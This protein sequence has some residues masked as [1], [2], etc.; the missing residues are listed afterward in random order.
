M[1]KKKVRRDIRL[2]RAKGKPP[3]W[4]SRKEPHDDAVTKTRSEARLSAR[5]ARNQHVRGCMYCKQ[6]LSETIFADEEYERRALEEIKR[7]IAECPE[8]PDLP[9]E[10]S[11]CIHHE[12]MPR[13]LA[14]KMIK[15]GDGDRPW[16]DRRDR[17]VSGIRLKVSKDDA[18]EGWDFSKQDAV[19]RHF[20][21]L[22]DSAGYV[23]IRL[24]SRKASVHVWISPSFKSRREDVHD[25]PTLEDIR[26]TY[27]K[28][29]PAIR[30]WCLHKYEELKGLAQM[31][32]NLEEGLKT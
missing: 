9:C 31:N 22:P 10:Y 30:T 11:G 6:I 32:L 28:S 25:Q 1:G 12:E 15:L 14:L 4:E 21:Y 29:V 16:R 26:E 3:A 13:A 27:E 19:R 20:I 8:P 17:L 5:R 7:H 24:G 23:Y 18:P 2:E